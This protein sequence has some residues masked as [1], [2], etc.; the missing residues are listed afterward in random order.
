MAGKKKQDDKE[1]SGNKLRTEAEKRVAGS[2]GKSAAPKKPDL[3]KLVHE[4]QI[5]QVE[6]EVQ[7]E[8]LRRTQEELQ[9][10][11]EQYFDLYDIAPVGYFVLSEKGVILEANLTGANML[12]V[13]P[14][15]LRAQLFSSLVFKADQDIYYLH[16][17]HLFA[18]QEPQACEMRMVRG[19]GT[20]L[21]A[22]VEAI[23][24]Q[25]AKSGK[26]VCR[27]V[28]SDISRQKQVEEAIQAGEEKYRT[29]ADFTNDLEYWM[30]P[31]G[32]Y[33]YVSPSCTAITGYHPEAFVQDPDLMLKIIH[34][35]DRDLLISHRKEALA[36]DK[37]SHYLD[38]RI[39]TL[40][41]NER[42]IGHKCQKVY[43][44]DGK[45]LGVRG[46]NRD[47]TEHKQMEQKLKEMAT[48]DYLTGLPNRV[49][50]SDRFTVAAALARRN[51]SRVAVM[52]LDLDHFKPINDTLG[53]D[54]G[55]QVLKSVGARLA[56]IIRAS[57]TVARTGGDEFILVLLETNH[58]K[59]STTIAQKV[60]NSFAEPLLI[61]GH[62][63]HLSTSIGIAIYPE[64]AEDMK[65]LTKKSDAALYYAKAHGR[66]QFKFYSDGDV[67]INGG[68]LKPAP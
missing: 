32:I 23:L 50:L 58:V 49:L 42:W 31:Q 62:Q 13:V 7:N 38:F 65:T 51:K 12:G 33:I 68:G 26:P 61:D 16:R 46:S 9:L 11:R 54:A 15:D 53:H 20:L 8:E 39:I 28:M 30:S 5:H 67:D 27:A 35:E 10:S 1:I 29:V 4:L 17:K 64:D 48:H 44:R 45:Y 40:A 41:G 25:H 24:A 60:L 18:T 14:R 52:S 36:T 55:D 59:D 34:P 57:D 22:R 6:L 37:K 63:L 47:I 43:G 3:D 19:D 2:S 66:N 21:W 56:G